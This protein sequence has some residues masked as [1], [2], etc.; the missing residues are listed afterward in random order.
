MNKILVVIGQ[1]QLNKVVD[2]TRYVGKTGK[3]L[4]SFSAKAWKI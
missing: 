1:F 4:Y 2:E 3:S